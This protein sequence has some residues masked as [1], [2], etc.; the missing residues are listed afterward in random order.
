MIG[1]LVA[2]S[3]ITIA[4]VHAIIYENNNHNQKVFKLK[5]DNCPVTTYLKKYIKS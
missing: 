1:K 3:G 4:Y 5:R 2:C